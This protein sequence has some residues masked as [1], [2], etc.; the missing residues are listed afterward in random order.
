MTTRYAP[1]GPEGQTLVSTILER[2]PSAEAKEPDELDATLL[3]QQV[4][5]EYY[6]MRNKMINQRGGFLKENTDP[7]QPLDEEEG[8]PKRLS[9]FKA[10]RLAGT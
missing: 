1:S 10:A 6:K 4:T 5:E 2:E 7:I 8:G 3:H 9:R